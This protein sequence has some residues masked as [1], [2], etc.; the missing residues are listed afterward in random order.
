MVVLGKYKVSELPCDGFWPVFS[1][2]DTE[3]NAKVAIKKISKATAD[4]YSVKCEIAILKS[5]NHSHMVS[6]LEVM[7]T[8]SNIYVVLDVDVE[9]GVSHLG[10]FLSTNRLDE[11]AARKYFRQLIEAL[12][13]CHL[14]GFPHQNIEPEKILL[15]DGNANI[16]VAE[17][18]RPLYQ[19]A[20]QPPG[21]Q[22]PSSTLNYVAPEALGGGEYDG[23]KADVW[24][25]GVVLFL[26]V[27]GKLPFAD[28]NP[29]AL[30]S[31][32]EGADYQME[33][34]FSDNLKD[35]I[36]VMLVAD[37]A[38]R[39]SIEAISGHQWLQN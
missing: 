3:T 29:E 2:T 25:C 26:M 12:Q 16:K 21:V 13:Y 11:G 36:S 8:A 34:G 6:M 24:S 33:A 38:A 32:I 1:A 17:I 30:R 14:Q 23:F 35:L 15:L 18:Q 4:E 28:K 31:K 10:R 5:L 37:P 39:A 19:S 7:Q 20:T 27:A 9:D 22:V